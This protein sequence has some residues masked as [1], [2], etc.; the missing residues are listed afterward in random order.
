M[1][2]AAFLLVTPP[3]EQSMILLLQLNQ[4]FLQLNNR[5][6]NFP[7]EKSAEHSEWTILNDSD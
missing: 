2:L 7:S 3:I 1:N 4:R 6:P 5:S